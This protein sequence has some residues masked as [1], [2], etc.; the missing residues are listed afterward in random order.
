VS[1][2]ARH[3]FRDRIFE[4]GSFIQLTPRASRASEFYQPGRTDPFNVIDDVPDRAMVVCAHPDDAEIGT[5]ATV[6]RWIEQGCEVVYV[7]CSD[8]SGGSNDDDMTSDRIVPVR[9]EEQSEAARVLGVKDVIMLG[10]P[11][12]GLEDDR[13]FRG[14]IVRA[15]RTYRPHTVFCHDPHRFNGFQH[16]DHRMAGTVTSDAIYPYARDHLHYPE[17]IEE[18]LTPH[19]VRRLLF[20]GAD[21]PDVIVQVTS[22]HVETQIEALSKHASQV[23]GLAN[24]SADRPRFGERLRERSRRAAEPN[25]FEHGETFRQLI[26]RA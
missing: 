1:N 13:A 10:H 18:G 7:V 21:H 8:G 25:G 5:G 17:Q 26:A 16:R 23:L 2:R 24:E 19:K 15:I 6:A 12:G 11:D 9:K 4:Q 3:V 22:E 14:E 20:W